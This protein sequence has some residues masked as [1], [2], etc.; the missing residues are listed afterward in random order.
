MRKIVLCILM[1]TAISFCLTGFTFANASTDFVPFSTY[2]ATFSVEIDGEN[3]VYHDVAEDG[4]TITVDVWVRSAE[5]LRTGSVRIQFDTDVF[6]NAVFHVNPNFDTGGFSAVGQDIPNSNIANGIIVVGFAR[7]M[8]PGPIV[9]PDNAYYIGHIIFT[10]SSTNDEDYTKVTI[11]HPHNLTNAWDGVTGARIADV[12]IATQELT[13]T[14]DSA[15]TNTPPDPIF[16]DI[17]WELDGGSLVSGSMPTSIE[18]GTVI[19]MPLVQKDGYNFA[20]WVRVPSATLD[21]PITVPT[22]FGAIWTPVIKTTPQSP[23]P[24][25]PDPTPPPPDDWK[26]PDPWPEYPFPYLPPDDW[27]PGDPWP[28]TV[29][30][31]YSWT[32]NPTGHAEDTGDLGYFMPTATP[33]QPST[34]ATPEPIEA[35]GSWTWSGWIAD[36]DTRTF[37]GSFT[38]NP[39]TPNQYSLRFYSQGALFGDATTQDLGTTVTIPTTFPNRTGHTFMG[40]QLGGDTFTLYNGVWR[41]QNNVPFSMTMPVGGLTFTAFWESEDVTM[42]RLATPGNVQ[43]VETVVDG[44]THYLLVWDA[45]PGA[46]GY[47]IYLRGDAIGNYWARIYIED[48]FTNQLDITFWGAGSYIIQIV[49]ISQDED[50]ILSS[51][52]SPE[53]T[54]IRDGVSEPGGN[55][56]QPPTPP[57]Q[58]VPTEYGRLSAPAL[59]RNYN[60]F[61]WDAVDNAIGYAIYLNGIRIAEVGQDTLFFDID[62]LDLIYSRTYIFSVRA[63]GDLEDWYHSFKSAGS[64][65]RVE[66]PDINNG[67]EFWW[68]V[69]L[70]GAATGLLAA[71]LFLAIESNRRRG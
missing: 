47:R 10:I 36:T 7:I 4:N 71:L 40:W 3:E 64:V 28:G 13:V 54:H 23:F 65:F 60:F 56:P 12:D 58:T 50:V 8:P 39:P 19:T 20:E 45:A 52:R 31:T 17:T 42:P 35:G 69:A 59:V 38:W 33:T 5:S 57:G 24:E 66:Q 9:V 55:P 18:Q 41:D 14:F 22:A 61:T 2:D 21:A 48:G 37:T 63:L 15:P 53:L 68:T 29:L 1:L 6:S 46:A 62:S 44:T 70:S 43:I 27:G 16:H 49:A 34:P 67:L 32:T 51:L 26:M 11:E 25:Y 30:W